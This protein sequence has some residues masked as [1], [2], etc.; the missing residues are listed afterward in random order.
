MSTHNDHD[1]L[2]N[3]Q[4]ETS[5]I[6]AKPILTFMGVLVVATIFIFVVIK[7]LLIGFNKIDEANLGQPATRVTLPGGQRKLPPEPRLQGAPG[8]SGPSLLPLEDMKEYRNQINEKAAS[9]GWVSKDTGVAHIPLDRAKAL[10][11]ERGLPMRPET[12]VTEIR[13]A[14]TVRKQILNADS[15]GGRIK[16]VQ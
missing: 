14:E 9:Y 4:P 3:L 7:G 10:I 15:S 12:A 11:V 16:G 2:N 13:S 6:K 8:V 1:D 5:G